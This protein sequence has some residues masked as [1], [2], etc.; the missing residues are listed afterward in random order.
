MLERSMDGTTMPDGT[1]VESVY[2]L[3]AGIA[4]A[5]AVARDFASTDWAE[6]AM[7]YDL[8]LE[9]DPDASTRLGWL[10]ARS[11]A[12]GP[13]AVLTETQ[14][15][16]DDDATARDHRVY[17]LLGDLHSRLGETAAAS[18]AFARAAALA[19]REAERAWLTARAEVG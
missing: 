15:L 3:Y 5:H 17:A 11:H 7:S 2:H 1:V 19:P 10:V 4:A 16:L 12:E 13:A 6:I 18:R 14:S 9:L 8:L